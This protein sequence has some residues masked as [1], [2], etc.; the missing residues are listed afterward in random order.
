MNA[1]SFGDLAQSALLRRQNSHLKT[2]M[3][4]LTQ[5]LSSGQVQ[6]VSKHLGGDYGYLTEIERSL[7]MVSAFKTSASEAALFTASMQNALGFVGDALQSMSIESIAAGTGGIAGTQDI[8]SE[9]ARKQLGLI[10]S[11]L[12]TN[13]AGR[14]AFAGVGTDGEALASAEDMLADLRAALAGQSTTAGV[15]SV[16][17]AW[18]DD[19]G[20]GFE[21][22]TYQGAAQSLEPFFLGEGERISLDIRA[23]DPAIRNALK[24]TAMAALATDA[25]LAF[26]ADVKADM[27]L[28]A[29]ETML[30]AQDNVTTIRAKLGF[31]E[32][33][34][35][36]ANARLASEQTSFEFTRNQLLGA[37]PYETITQLEETQFRLESLYAA[38]AKMSQLSLMDYL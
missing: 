5:E 6:D 12:N 1:L 25:T 28:K 13:V 29:G 32:A 17:D 11:S 15:E 20:G 10:V 30:V 23:D 37:D 36:D 2:E 34:I 19:A 27:L 26:S 14:T 22:A 18:F 35:E 33:R 4:R 9:N 16:L 21:T 38:T 3:S 24:A 8:A 31:A 7:R